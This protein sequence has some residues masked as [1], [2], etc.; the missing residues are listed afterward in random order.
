MTEETMMAGGAG[1]STTKAK[2]KSNAKSKA[3]AAP[4]SAAPKSAAP[5]QTPT[6]QAAGP[7]TRYVSPAAAVVRFCRSL[8]PEEAEDFIVRAE[9]AEAVVTLKATSV[10]FV[11]RFLVAKRKR[12]VIEL[13]SI[14]ASVREVDPCPGNDKRC[15]KKS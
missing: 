12:A 7:F 9:R 4:K 10:A 1:R 15:F 14:T 5:K 13:N 6:K 8:T 3:K 11:D 2:A